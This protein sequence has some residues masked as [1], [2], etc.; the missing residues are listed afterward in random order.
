MSRAGQADAAGGVFRIVAATFL[1]IH[2]LR[3]Q[4]VVGL[5][6]PSDV[7]AVHLA[8]ETD[9]PTD[10]LVATMSDGRRCF[11][12][13]KRAAGNDRHLKD[14]VEGWVAQM[15]DVRP[16]DLLVLAA[17]DLK[18]PVRDLAEA[19]QRRRD[20]RAL[21]GRHDAAIAAVS[22]HVPPG[23]LDDLLDRVRVLHIPSATGAS[24][25]QALLESMAGYLVEGGDGAAVVSLLSHSFNAQASTASASSIADWVQVIRKGS[26]PLIADG[27]GPAGMRL[28]ASLAAGEEY[29]TAL[30]TRRGR[31]DLTLLAEDL[32]PVTVDGLLDGLQVETGENKRSGGDDFLRVIRRWRRMLLVGQPGTGKSVALRELAADCASDP[33]AP[34]P[35]LVHL[36]TL[37]RGDPDSVSV[38]A[39]IAAAAQRVIGQ[40]S[41]DALA[42][43]MRKEI[44]EGTAILLFDGLD[45]CGPK[46]AWMAQQLKEVIAEVG[47]RVGVV[48]A[49][50][51][52]A[53]KA[54]Q[55]LELPRA[56]LLPPSDLTETVNS[57]LDACA[58][59]RSGRGR[60]EGWLAVRR[61]WLSEARKQHAEL[62]QVPL[63][64]VLLALV[65]AD[66]ADAELPKGRARLL[67]AAVEQSVTRWE[68]TRA[69]ATT[70]AWTQELDGA[71]LLDGY[72][73]LGRLLDAGA[74]PSQEQ[75]LTALA[76]MLRDEDRWG[77][78]PSRGRVVATDI[79]R[80][81]DEHVAVFVVNGSGRLSAR[82]KVFT[83]IATA[84]WTLTATDDDIE[85]WLAEALPYTD[86]DGAIGLAAGLNGRVVDALLTVSGAVG[87]AS[88]LLAELVSRGII[89]LTEEQEAQLLEQVK[90]AVERTIRGEEQPERTPR[91]PSRLWFM[92]HGRT[93]GRAQA[94]WKY[95]E[96][97]CALK[98]RPVHR[99]IRDEIIAGSA[100]NDA[101]A[102][103]ARALCALTDAECDGRNLDEHGIAAVT[104]VMEQPLPPDGE[105][106]RESRRRSAFVGGAP[107]PSGVAKVALGATRHLAVLPTD[108]ARWTFEVSMKASGDDSAEIRSTLRAKRVDTRGWESEGNPLAPLL[109]RHDDDRRHQA[110]LEDTAALGSA[111]SPSSPHLERDHG[112]SLTA[113]GD[114]LQATKY[115]TVTWQEFARAFRHDAPAIRRDWLDAVADAYRIDKDQAAREAAWMLEQRHE[116]TESEW[117]LDDNWFVM[118]MPTP[119]RR[120][121][122]DEALAGLSPSQHEALLK[123][124]DADSDWLA[125][126]A[127]EVL[128]NIPTPTW[129]AVT[130]FR[131]DMTTWPLD[132][133]ALLYMVAIL[134]A[135][136]KGPEL[137]AMAAQ[138]PAPEYRIA[139]R[140]SAAVGPA[141]DQGGATYERL[142]RDPDL[143]VRD[144]SHRKDDPQAEYWTCRICRQRNDIETED[145]PGCDEGTRPT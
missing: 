137:F 118:T 83:E 125:W 8:F 120:E 126:S 70:R 17:E 45:E 124:L 12:S 94:G 16:D 78:A 43:W 25:I 106:V 24:H 92:L 9:D 38:G 55:R 41:R 52:N 73:V 143:V 28:A 102:E 14:T 90:R 130:L 7:G 60:V 111:H 69:S 101:D 3:E 113:V 66:T 88:T 31:I 136:E 144:R 65:C 42:R 21:A 108:A 20:G 68:S 33:T 30:C 97:I 61:S 62:F 140:D 67:H 10:D 103:M 89:E 57:V 84:M 85:D 129:D 29:Q 93:D 19:L 121:L 22:Q 13:A 76:E 48:V 99:S 107:L 131:T 18:G 80:F 50:R 82:S 142:R 58:E 119:T 64:A 114:L 145:C 37:L 26:R 27:T 63:L 128:I 109:A 95:V 49:T 6:L 98:L 53:V 135:G 132:R 59:A 115:G 11:I 46:A 138:S 72:V 56:D 117:V 32:S 104:S 51:A 127:A 79:L 122:T 74:E 105:L 139:A 112:W 15:R 116:A 5:R 81:W 54:A 2:A 44:D 134:T 35:I 34:L 71:M 1:A 39:V 91:E 87:S 133:A 4:E 141:L 86:S 40:E 77:L 96:L 23:I 36:P 110:L 123:A 47:P 75:A 100:L